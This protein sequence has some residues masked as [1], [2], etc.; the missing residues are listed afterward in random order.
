[1]EARRALTRAIKIAEKADLP[2]RAAQARSSLV[3]V[4]V[5]LGQF[6]AALTEADAAAPALARHDRGLLLAQRAVALSRLDR[7]DDALAA[8]AKALATLPHSA[9]ALQAMVLQNRGLLHT[10]RGKFDD[11]ERDLQRCLELAR[12][13]GL[14]AVAA[15]A[16][17]NVGYLALLEGDLV[18]ALER[19][20]QSEGQRREFQADPLP[21][22]LDRAEVLLAANLADEARQAARTAVNIASS[23]GRQA[24]LAEAELTLARALL[25]AGDPASA[26]HHAV[27]ARSRFVRQGRDGWAAIASEIALRGRVAGGERGRRVVV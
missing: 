12:R 11:A 10:Y 3:V 19:L 5:S 18:A 1:M 24:D 26:R 22:L 17:H 16:L 2:V 8:Y 7:T 9:V 20:D 13:H 23:S 15:D 27:R 14:H 4:L 25:I 6:D 21:W